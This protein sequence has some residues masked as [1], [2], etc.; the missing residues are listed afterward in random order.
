MKF[1]ILC[2][3]LIIGISTISPVF[4]PT[5]VPIPYLDFERMA[6]TWYGIWSYP[7]S[8]NGTNATC[9]LNSVRTTEDGNIT[10]NSSI[11][12]NGTFVNHTISMVVASQQGSVWNS[13]N[14]TQLTWIAVDPVS[15]SWGLGVFGS[16]L[17]AISRTK[18][19]S[20]TIIQAQA[21]LA[22]KEGY[23]METNLTLFYDN[24]NCTFSIKF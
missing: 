17:F 18:N 7:N 11:T 15:Y 6:G 13:T 5:P 1:L 16:E 14:N 9:W 19:L 2:T 22:K 4:D 12:L 10:W 20:S 3:L 8:T 23:G 24:S 21:Q